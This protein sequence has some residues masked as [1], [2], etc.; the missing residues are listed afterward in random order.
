MCESIAGEAHYKRK[1]KRHMEITDVGTRASEGHCCRLVHVPC[2][3][4]LRA[5]CGTAGL[6][7]GKNNASLRARC[8]TVDLSD[9]GDHAR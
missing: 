2:Q 3:D 4:N 8:G 1:A 5:R 7:D 9:G 6:S